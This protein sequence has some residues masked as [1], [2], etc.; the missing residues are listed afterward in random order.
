MN[1][2]GSIS[3]A[4]A[5]AATSLLRHHRTSAAE[6]LDP[7]D[8]QKAGI[9]QGD[10]GKLTSGRGM[11]C[12]LHRSCGQICPL[13]DIS[14]VFSFSFS[15]VLVEQKK[16]APTCVAADVHPQRAVAGELL[17]A[18]RTDLLLLARVSL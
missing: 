8:S 9:L 7:G 4:A 16:A 15:R 10:A 5:A 1:T 3:V 14:G 18:V 17:A 2:Q 6:K 12:P 13:R 11:T